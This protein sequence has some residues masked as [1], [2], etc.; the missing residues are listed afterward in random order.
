M[1]VHRLSILL[2]SHETRREISL[3]IQFFYFELEKHFI[4]DSSTPAPF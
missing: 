2:L 1:S 4:Q 3:F